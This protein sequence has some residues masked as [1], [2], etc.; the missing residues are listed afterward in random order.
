VAYAW[1]SGRRWPT[2]AET[3]RA[4][5]RTGIDVRAAL[6]RFYGTDPR[7]MPADPVSPQALAIFMD[8]LRGSHPVSALARESGLSRYALTR[9]LSGQTQPRL[10]D[11]F[12]YIEAT[13]LRLVDF[14]TSFVEPDQVPAIADTWARLEARR[15]GAFELPWTQAVIRAF[16]L[17][18]YRALPCHE[19][20]W[21]AKRL[22]IPEQEAHRCIDHLIETGQLRWEGKH[23]ALDAIAVDTRRRPD[24]GRRLKQHWTQVAGDRIRDGAPGQFS[25]NVFTVSRADFERIRELHLNYY[26]ELRNVVANSEPGECVAIANVQLFALDGQSKEPQE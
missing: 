13:S 20:T 9:W 19:T 8:D 3:L 1:E 6:S 11:F 21:I 18:D 2:A 12:H 23:L 10:P 26:Q 15:R 14:I 22:G 16:E 4:A 5:Q 7:W 17:A 25:Y 24:V